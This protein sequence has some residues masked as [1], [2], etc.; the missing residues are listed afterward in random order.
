MRSSGKGVKEM[1]TVTHQVEE[2]KNVFVSWAWMIG[3]VISLSTAV[4]AG[5]VFYVPLENKQVALL[6]NHEKRIVVL[7][8]IDLNL[9]TI[10]QILRSK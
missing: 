10:K 1:S 9:D 5:V 2:C 3:V 4:V 8:K 6:E 7:E